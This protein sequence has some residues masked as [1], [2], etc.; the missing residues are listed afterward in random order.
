MKIPSWVV[1]VHSVWGARIGIVDVPVMVMPWINKFRCKI[2]QRK[3]KVASSSWVFCQT[4]C[5]QNFPSSL[6]YLHVTENSEKIFTVVHSQ[7]SLGLMLLSNCGFWCLS[8]ERSL[9]QQRAKLHEPAQQLLMPRFVSLR[10]FP[11]S[12]RTIEALLHIF[13]WTRVAWILSFGAT[14]RILADLGTDAI[15]KSYCSSGLEECF[16]WHCA[17]GRA[18]NSATKWGLQVTVNSSIVSF[19]NASSY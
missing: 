17:D 4:A 7:T 18:R 6:K 14:H 16:P 19:Y 10:I 13:T 12:N 2:L 8:A 3:S 1:I 11:K 5:K 9:T 15:V